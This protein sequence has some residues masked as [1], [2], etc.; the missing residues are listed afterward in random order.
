MPLNVSNVIPAVPFYCSCI[1]FIFLKQTSYSANTDASR[2]SICWITSLLFSMFYAHSLCSHNSL[3]EQGSSLC[4]VPLSSSPDTFTVSHF[5]SQ[6]SDEEG[7]GARGLITVLIYNYT[8]IFH[9]AYEIR[10]S[11]LELDS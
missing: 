11:P 7:L 3:C 1:I 6:P 10:T 5:G 9:T 8:V 4:P 2:A